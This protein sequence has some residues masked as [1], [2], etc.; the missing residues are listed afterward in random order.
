MKIDSHHKKI[1]TPFIKYLTKIRILKAKELLAD[2][3][4]QV[5]KVAESVGY[6]ST[7]H[8]TKLFTEVIGCYPSEYQKKFKN[9]EEK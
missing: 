6:Y 2:P 1:G 8:F 4:N 9:K 3:Q 7:R 5:Q